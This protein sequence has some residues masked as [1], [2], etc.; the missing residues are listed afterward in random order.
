MATGNQVLPGA[1]VRERGQD[2]LRRDVPR[3]GSGGRWLVWIMRVV[4]WAVLLLIGYRGVLAIVSEPG[5]PT[6]RQAASGAP[7]G[8]FPTAAASAYALAF[9]QDYLN[10]SPATATQRSN[11]LA[12]FLP[13][14]TDPQLG[15]DGGGTESLQF[16][17][18]AGVAVHDAQHAVVTLLAQVSGRLIE[19]GVPVYASGGALVVSGQPALLPAPAKAA[20][21]APPSVA[22]DTATQAA[23]ARQL[24]AFF[25]AYASGDAAT[26]GRFLASD[27]QV[28]GLGGVVSYGGI[29][30]ISVPAASGDTRQVEVTVVWR[31]GGQPVAGSSSVATTPAHIQMTYALTVVRSNGTWY[32]RSI[33]AAALPGPSS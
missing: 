6:G 9:G 32:V 1:P 7:A 5:G 31:M 29:Q 33:G 18:V 12:A 14:G 10:Y 25:R 21:P 22:A 16:E 30:Q 4:V 2:R 20:L 8:G 28:T 26:L 3:R 27:A 19:L 11:E 23:L 24:P 15:W 17:Q 13:A